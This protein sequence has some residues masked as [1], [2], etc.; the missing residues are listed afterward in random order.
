[1]PNPPM[2]SLSQLPQ[3]PIFLSRYA[4]LPE[5][6]PAP[7]PRQAYFLRVVT[8]HFPQLPPS[9][10]LSNLIPKSAVGELSEDSSNVVQLIMDA[11]NVRGW[12]GGALGKVERD[13][14]VGWQNQE[15]NRL[16]VS[17]PTAPAHSLC[18]WLSLTAHSVLHSFINLKCLISTEHEA[19][20]WARKG[21]NID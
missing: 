8:H 17:H 6:H 18:V 4:L 20:L 13:P 3:R 1:M 21:I 14:Q 19:L 11:Y 16:L 5:S 7:R 10:E 9:Q 12:G 2:P 15:D